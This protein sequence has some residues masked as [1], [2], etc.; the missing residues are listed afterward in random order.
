M[1]CTGGDMA[2]RL[3]LGQEQTGGFNDILSPHLCPRQIGRVAFS[4]NG[5]IPPVDNDTILTCGNGPG[6]LAVHRIVLQHVGQI[7]GGAQI[8]DP[9]DL[10]FGMVQ[11]AAQH[12]T[13]NTSKSIDTNFNAHHIRILSF[14]IYRMF[15]MF[16]LYNILQEMSSALLLSHVN[17]VGGREYK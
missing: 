14:G 8:I 6:K 13:A 10:N 7:I 4:K 16:G 5:D 15:G 9:H 3:F 17:K 12:H 2:L 11:A 1:L